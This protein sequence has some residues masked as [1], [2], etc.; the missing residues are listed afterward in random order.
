MESDSK[1]RR[2]LR[3]PAVCELMGVSPSTLERMIRSGRFP[4]PVVISQRTRG[5]FADVVAA[6]QAELVAPVEGR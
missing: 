5:W 3:R 4:A 6:K 1:P 2:L